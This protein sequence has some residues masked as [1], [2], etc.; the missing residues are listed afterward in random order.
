MANPNFYGRGKV[1]GDLLVK[2]QLSVNA[3]FPDAT[4]DNPLELGAAVIV[5]AGEN[6]GY[7]ATKA[8]A[9]EAN[10]ILLQSVHNATENVGVLV[11][12]EIKESFYE[13]PLSKDLRTSLL[14]SGIVLR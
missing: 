1:L 14:N 11:A 8:P 5:S 6:G 2:T 7:T 12:G 9:N 10:G 4:E 13:T 3:T